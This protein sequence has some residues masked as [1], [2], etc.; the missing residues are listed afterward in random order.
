MV[1]EIL[2]EFRFPG[3]IDSWLGTKLISSPTILFTGA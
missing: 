2:N 3:V 1:F